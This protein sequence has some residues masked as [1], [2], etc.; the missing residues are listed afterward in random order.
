[1]R[2]AIPP[3]PQHVLST[4]VAVDDCVGEMRKVVQCCEFPL[5]P[6]AAGVGH[7]LEQ[8]RADALGEFVPSGFRGRRK[9]CSYRL[10]GA[11][12]RQSRQQCGVLLGHSFD[13]LVII[14]CVVAKRFPGNSAEQQE[15]SLVG[16]GRTAL[17]ERLRGAE[18]ELEACECA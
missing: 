8:L 11:G 15:R 7:E 9:F 18:P 3:L 14:E 1:M 16:T 13:Q 2:Q 10:V 6:E 12:S 4:E 17:E 5:G